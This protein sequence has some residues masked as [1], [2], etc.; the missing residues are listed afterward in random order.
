MNTRLLAVTV[1]LLLVGLIALFSLQWKI[2]T[3]GFAVESPQEV[4]VPL[5]ARRVVGGGR[6]G[7]EFDGRRD[8]HADLKVRCAS[9]E[10]WVT[11]ETG[12]TSERICTVRIRLTG[13]SSATGSLSSSRA[14]LEVTW[15]SPV[16]QAEEPST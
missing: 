8:D 6:A 1:M 4:V 2:G 12:E 13:F 11:L 16:P 7:V 9:G 5:G 3:G 15:Q 14:H 10:R